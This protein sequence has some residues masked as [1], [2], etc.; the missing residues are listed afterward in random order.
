MGQVKGR[1]DNA[2]EKI[3]WEEVGRKFSGTCH[4]K[5]SKDRQ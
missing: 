2:E 3:G 5:I 4:G 1:T